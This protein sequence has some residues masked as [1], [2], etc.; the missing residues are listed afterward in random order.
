M[1]SQVTPHRFS[2]ALLRILGRD[3]GQGQAGNAETSDQNAIRLRG[4]V[5]VTTG[6]TQ[7]DHKISASSPKPDICALMSTRS[8]CGPAQTLK[9]SS[10]IN[11]IAYTFFFEYPLFLLVPAKH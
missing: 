1:N 8:N 2:L 7:H 6:K 4:L 5:W 10:G 9:C 3:T 11:G